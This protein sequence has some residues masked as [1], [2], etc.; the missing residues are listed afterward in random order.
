MSE[1]NPLVNEDET[2]DPLSAELAIE[3]A[4][5]AKI[6]ESES[7]DE[8]DQASD[9]VPEPEEFQP[10]FLDEESVDSE[11]SETVAATETISTQEDDDEEL[12]SVLHAEFFQDPGRQTEENNG[13][14]Q[15]LKTVI[16]AIDLKKDYRV[17]WL[18]LRKFRALD[19]VSFEVKPGEIFGFLGPNGA[20]KTTTIKTL[21]GITKPTS[22]SVELF[23]QKG[24]SKAARAKL[25]YFPE[26]SYYYKY[27][28]AREAVTYYG[29]LFG[30]PR[31]KLKDRVK[32]VL[33]L[34]GLY[35]HQNRLLK[36]F[37]K[38][39]LQRLG[40]AQ[41]LINDPELLVMDE[42]T[43]GLDPIMKKEMR[44][45]IL[46]LNEHGMTIFFSSH[47]LAEVEM[48]C[49]RV[50]IL[51]E[52]KI[53]AEGPISEILP[54]EPGVTIVV[55]S[56]SKQTVFELGRRGVSI[57]TENGE[58]L[59]RCDNVN[60]IHEVLYILG[61]SRCEVVDVKPHKQS[62]EDFFVK[63]VKEQEAGVE[64]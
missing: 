14:D 60:R 22:G 64:L 35:E 42:P 2:Q 6:T 57:S 12:T 55:K 53:V 23:G 20:G 13:P 11:A 44:D 9:D 63:T 34:V 49:H 50:A 36:K 4:E 54:S 47:E 29:R 51:N 33:N 19:G 31:A 28:S 46:N 52:G 18:Q 17:G 25:G 7:I 8:V 61:T 37:S 39:M 30:I 38:G 62:L 24:P 21:L 43:S 45:L 16:K 26:I 32:C 41:A 3:G 15:V 59:V 58:L 27:L 5:W 10:T 1:K 40:F 48:I 56:L